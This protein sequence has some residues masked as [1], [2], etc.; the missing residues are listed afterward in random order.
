[1]LEASI[2]DKKIRSAG[3]PIDGISKE[4][5]SYRI[6]FRPEA[7]QQQRNTAAAIVAAFDPA[8]ATTRE[9]EINNAPGI[10][11]SYFT[12]HQAAIN[13]VRLTPVEQEAQI[14]AMTT[15]QMKTLLKYLTIAVSFLIKR[16]LL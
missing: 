10:A 15:T 1:M 3:I 2:L 8:E 16:E 7:T 14:D 12:S 4:N 9:A 6:D 5:G 11:K 13:F